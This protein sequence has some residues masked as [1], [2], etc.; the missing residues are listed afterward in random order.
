[1]SVFAGKA[2]KRFTLVEL[3][4]VIAIISILSGLLLPALK[5][6]RD[7]ARKI[8][9]QSRLKQWY[10][11][12]LQYSDDHGGMLVDMTLADPLPA[13]CPRYWPPRVAGYLPAPSG[14]ISSG[15]QAGTTRVYHELHECP[16]DANSYWGTSYGINYR[17]GSYYYPTH[18]PGRL[19]S[20]KRPS[21]SLFQGDGW[22]YA[23]RPTATCWP[24][25]YIGA[26]R[27]E[28]RGNFFFLDGHV[29]CLQLSVDHTPYMLY[30]ASNIFWPY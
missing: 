30:S 22:N 19:S 5:K 11:V 6:A 24:D 23:L 9:C 10:L 3:L 8:D 18:I 16:S 17:F 20:F 21:N 4:V 1:M 15:S 26:S 12:H 25:D 28:T 7:A 13:G 27:H 2:A 14:K 29:E